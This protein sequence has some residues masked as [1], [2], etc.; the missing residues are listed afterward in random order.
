M[1]RLSKPKKKK[2]SSNGRSKKSRMRYWGYGYV[3]NVTITTGRELD[4]S[5]YKQNLLQELNKDFNK[6]VLFVYETWNE[7][8]DQMKNLPL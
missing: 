4:D 2:L 3:G 8:W 6:L 1:K 5:K 7:C